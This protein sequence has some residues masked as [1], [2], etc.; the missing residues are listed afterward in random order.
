MNDSNGL[1]PEMSS[2]A[3]EAWHVLKPQVKLLLTLEFS[4][5]VIKMSREAFKRRYGELGLQR[6]LEAH[7]GE[8]LARGALG[9]KYVNKIL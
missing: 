6:W 1:H 5:G 4:S 8:K 2:E 7:Y 3:R 9:D